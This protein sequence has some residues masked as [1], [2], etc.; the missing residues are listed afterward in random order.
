MVP[1]DRTVTTAVGHGK[2]AA[3]HIDAWL[4]GTRYRPPPPPPIAAAELLRPWFATDAPQ[5][6]QARLTGPDRASGFE[7][8]TGG[9]SEAEANFEAMRCL[10][11]GNC[12]ECDGCYGACPEDA[13]IKLGPGQRYRFDYERC[14]GCGVCFEQCPC[15]AIDM[16]PEPSGESGDGG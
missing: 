11:C 5:R 14:T 4:A 10:S 16:I 1:A 3:R 15:H 8:V 13:V 9:L 2:F 7:E 6:Q 12:F